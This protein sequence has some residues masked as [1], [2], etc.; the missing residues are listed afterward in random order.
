MSEWNKFNCKIKVFYYIAGTRERLFIEKCELKKAFLFYEVTF[1]NYLFRK[2]KNKI[3]TFSNFYLFLK[4]G[5][6]WTGDDIK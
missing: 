5:M 2:N 4:L 3:D 1:S 6:I